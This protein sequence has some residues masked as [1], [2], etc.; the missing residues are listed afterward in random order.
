MLRWRACL[1]GGHRRSLCW[2][3]RR[4]RRL[5]SQDRALALYPACQV[6]LRTQVELHRA[7]CVIRQ[8]DIGGGL[9]Y[10]MDLLDALP[11][12]HRTA[13]LYKVA[14]DMLASVPVRERHRPEVR[15]IGYR[16]GGGR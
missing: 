11:G 15:E 3:V 14:S 7:T 6:R 13:N 8:G 9:R 16:I 2:S 10:A 5:T 1:P 12:E 4:R